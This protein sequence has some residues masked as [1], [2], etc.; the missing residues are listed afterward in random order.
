MLTKRILLTIATTVFF[1]VSFTTALAQTSGA[2]E[3][4]QRIAERIASGE[5]MPVVER[6]DLET[7]PQMLIAASLQGGLTDILTRQKN[8]LVGCWELTLTF[9]DGSRATS[10]LSV[11]PGRTDGEG[12]ILHAAEASLLLP[13]P[14]TPEQGAWQH[15]G[16][17]QFVAS[18]SGYAVD[19]KFQAPFGKIGFRQLITLNSDQESFTGKGKFEVI[20]GATGM[21][22]FSDTVQVTGKRMRA[23]AP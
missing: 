6:F 17:L 16:G 3:L 15:N 1:A 12:T 18:Y 5:R 10:T 19:E 20:E 13:N 11:F 9:S 14:T 22:V 2:V 4:K 21:V 23:V 7:P 8:A